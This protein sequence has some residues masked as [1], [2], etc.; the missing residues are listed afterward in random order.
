MSVSVLIVDD[1]PRIRTALSEALESDAVIVRTAHSAD[2]GLEVLA[3]APVD[4]VLAD[5]RMPGTDG[6]GL[7]RILRQRSPQ[8]DVILMTA[9]ED[10]PT[11][12]A[13]MRDGAVDFL[14]KPLDLFRLREIL[15]RVLGDRATRQHRAGAG[16]PQP[17]TS[18]GPW[19]VGRDPAMIEVFK[20][21]GH[22]AATASTVLIR[23]ESGTGKELIARSI[24]A[25]SP[26]A[27][28]PFV[29]VNCAAIPETLLESELFGHV[30]GAFTGA[31]GD[32]QGRFSLARG[33]TILLDEIGDTSVDFQAKLLRVLQDSE[34]YPVGSEKPQKSSARVIAATHQ[35]LEELV[36]RS[37]FRHDLYYRLRV[38]EIVVPPLRNRTGDIRLLA[39][40]LLQRKSRTLERPAPVLTDESVAVLM[41]H[42]WPG[43]VRELE[44]CLERAFVLAAGEVIRPDHLKLAPAK[45]EDD[46]PGLLS[47]GDAER[48]HIGRV[49]EA[50]RG[51]KS[52]AAKILGVSRPRLDRLIDKYGLQDL[53]AARGRSPSDH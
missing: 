34:Y 45:E 3:D 41:A 4:V 22:A 24:H 6:L 36:D 13:A 39:D 5:V 12:A 21:V 20:L 46:S 52:R 14:T 32:R 35:D 38:V 26:R 40:N 50:S 11:V 10:L 51:N 1:D 2:A 7:L 37:E 17:E 9:F 15:S 16:V 43:N 53:T 27:E 48:T 28:R 42:D 30:R 25:L 23:G 8:T 18:A 49:L 33:G 19:L 31:T 29:A 44:N 47:L